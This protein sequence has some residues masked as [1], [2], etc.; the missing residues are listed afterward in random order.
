M[1]L[2]GLSNVARLSEGNGGVIATSEYHLACSF[3]RNGGTD[4]GVE[5]AG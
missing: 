2:T 3:K 1:G 5:A 4:G